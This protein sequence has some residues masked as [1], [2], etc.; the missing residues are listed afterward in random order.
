MNSS[1]ICNPGQISMVVV[2][3]FVQ[4]LVYINIALAVF[5]VSMPTFLLENLHS[6]KT[7]LF[8]VLHGFWIIW[9]H[10][11]LITQE[12]F[13]LFFYSASLWHFSTFYDFKTLQRFLDVKSCYAF[14]V[15]FS[16]IFDE[17]INS[18]NLLFHRSFCYMFRAVGLPE[19]KSLTHSQVFFFF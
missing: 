14:P 8:A 19:S 9:I 3:V 6:N 5:C 11:S 10:E 4:G 13:F 7:I 18:H 12:T 2:L 15:G 16:W 1:G 17:A